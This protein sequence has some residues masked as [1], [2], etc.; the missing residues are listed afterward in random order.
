M[1]C[2]GMIH[3]YYTPGCDI[4]NDLK[5][6]VNICL[7]GNRDKWDVEEGDNNTLAR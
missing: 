7:E 4:C 5:R 3:E 2:R 6:C 1:D